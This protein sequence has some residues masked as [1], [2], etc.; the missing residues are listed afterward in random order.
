MGRYKF[1]RHGV[2]SF[3]VFLQISNRR[4]LHPD[5]PS[6][7]A[8]EESFHE[9]ALSSF[10]RS[11]CPALLGLCQREFNGCLLPTHDTRHLPAEG[12]GCSHTDHEC[13]SQVPVL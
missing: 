10:D 12:K 13:G 7:K 5:C 1:D 8:V 2:S 9:L 4:L 6:G 11:T 3:K